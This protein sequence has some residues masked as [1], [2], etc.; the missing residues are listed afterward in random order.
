LGADKVMVVFFL[1]T[2]DELVFV[3]AG[4]Q[5]NFVEISHS[6]KNIQSPVNS[7]QTNPGIYPEKGLIDLFGAQVF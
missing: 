1:G 7:G 3:F 5:W 6:F 2:G 4:P